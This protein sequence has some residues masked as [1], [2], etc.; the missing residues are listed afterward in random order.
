MQLFS[1]YARGTYFVKDFWPYLVIDATCILLLVFGSFYIFKSH[2]SETKKK[3]L[4]LLLT[5]VCFFVFI[6]SG[7]EAYF[8]YKY[9]ESD[10]L[11]FLK[12][13]GRW[14]ERHV[15]PNNYGFRDEDFKEVKA[16]GVTR[17]GIVGDSMAFGYGI[18]NVEDRFSEL[19]EKK[20][21]ASGR[22]VEVYNLG[23]SGYD[24]WNEI[25]EFK[26]VDHL[27]FDIIV[28]EYFLND[29]QPQQ[30]RGKKVLLK[31]Q[32]QSKL[33]REITSHSY[34]LDYIYWRLAAKYE[35]TF[36]KLRQADV[37]SYHDEKNFAKHKK[38]VSTFAKQ[39]KNDDRKV[40]VLLI[41]FIKF[42]PE[43]PLA[44]KYP[45]IKQMFAD[46]NL[47]VIDMYEDLRDKKSE[48][49]LVSRFDYHPNEVVQ[50]IIADR[51]YAKIAPLVPNK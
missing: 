37:D 10:S 35:T 28:W 39:L 8:R 1:L 30:S 33:A 47:P 3:I 9:D 49:V 25:E 34:F 27:D 31:E 40:V 2:T 5:C 6:F 50:E 17:I 36:A 22:N 41:P 7:F 48:D 51:L 32:E 14:L 42:L 46:N 11:G 44:D 12:I 29:A 24:T 26:R 45:Q 23:K 13:T 21:L 15:V 16:N 20:L 43:N 18:K 4:L 38:Q 19:L